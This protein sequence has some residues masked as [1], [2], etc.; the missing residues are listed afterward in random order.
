MPEIIFGEIE[1]YPVGTVFNTLMEAYRAGVHRQTRAG[2]AGGGKTGSDS[3]VLMGQYHDIDNGHEIIYTGEGGF[4]RDTGLQVKDQSI[5]SSGNAGLKI[6]YEAEL[7]VRVL[8]GHK[9]D[10]R[11]S[12]TPTPP[13]TTAYKYDGLYL[14]TRY[15]GETQDG[16][17]IWRYRLQRV[18]QTNILIPTTSD[19]PAPRNQVTSNRIVRDAA[20][21]RRIKEI[22][23]YTCQICGIRLETPSGAYSEA[24]HIKPLGS[25]D[26][27]P[28]VEANLLCLCPNHHKLMD[29]GGIIVN[30]NLQ[31][32]S[33]S[34]MS[35]VGT[36][37]IRPR[38]SINS[39]FLEW[40]RNRWLRES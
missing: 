39:E 34:D 10:S 5:T 14:V 17:R 11:W 6:S 28:D 8:R 23:D 40:H 30:S 37:D 27:G 4:D 15:W 18:D 1:G 38:H 20:L 33:T 36:L 2:I 22:Y 24:A 19:A 25:P 35:F 13:A 31:V 16:Y 21:V 12:P 32:V 29:A 3:V 7:P 9:G 26:D